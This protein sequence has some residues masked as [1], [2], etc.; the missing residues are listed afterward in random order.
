MYTVQGHSGAVL[1]Q[2]EAGCRYCPETELSLLQ[3]GYTIR[4]DGK[5]ITQKEVSQHVKS[6]QHPGAV[7]PRP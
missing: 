4:L 6:D 7:R 3:A 5:R 2:S 1:M